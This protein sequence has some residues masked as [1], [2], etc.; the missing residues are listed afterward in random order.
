MKRLVRDE[1]TY[2][3]PH[4]VHFQHMTLVSA[5][6]SLILLAVFV[7]GEEK[8]MSSV[9]VG[10]Q[11]SKMRRESRGDI[12]ETMATKAVSEGQ[13]QIAS[14]CSNTKVKER[15]RTR[16]YLEHGHEMQGALLDTKKSHLLSGPVT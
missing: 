16:R 12:A 10:C 3:R 2:R 4:F 14:H 5:Y 9:C 6:W 11:K 15:A 8:V 7:D 1:S 13:S